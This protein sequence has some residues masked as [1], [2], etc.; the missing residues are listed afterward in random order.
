MQNTAYYKRDSFRPIFRAI[1]R[2]VHH[3]PKEQ[4]CKLSINLIERDLFLHTDV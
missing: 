4:L 2:P 1:V 3:N